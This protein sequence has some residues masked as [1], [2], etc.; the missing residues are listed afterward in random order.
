MYNRRF[1]FHHTPASGKRL[2]F[3]RIMI[4]IIAEK[5][6]V[7]QDIARVVGATE[8]KDGYI[9]GNG[10]MVTWALGHLVSLA[11]PDAYG[12]TRTAAEDLP[13]IPDPFRLVVRQ[14]RT[15]RGMV[16][17]IA[18]GRQLK[19]IGEV[20]AGC[21]SI[22]VA[23]DAGREG[24]L[25][26]RW[27]Y[28]YLGCTKPF[29]RLWISSLTDEA[30]REGMASLKEGTGYDSLYAA[31]DSRAK[32]DWLVGMNA[33]R[34]LAAA[35]G[36]V[37]NSIGR[38]QTPTLAMICA[39]FKENRNFVSTPYWQ[40]HIVLKRDNGHR[41]FIHTKEFKDKN[42]AEAAYKSITPGSVVTITKVKRG[43]I[44]QQAP[45]LYDLTALQKDCNI[46]YDLPVDKT[47]A[48]TQSLY[49][50]KLVSYPRTGSRYI[51]QDVM[52]HIPVLLEKI[53]A[54][55]EFREYRRSL[56]L[57]ALNT[58]SLDAAK[59]T[60]HHAIIPTIEITKTDLSA[61]PE[62]EMKILSLVANR[63]LCATG[64]KQLYETVKAEFSCGGY[65]F[66]VSGKTVLQNGWKEFE[67][68]LKR[69]Y[70]VEKTDED[71]E[72]KK[73]PELSEGMT[74]PVIQTKVTEHFTQPPKHFTE[75]SLL[76]AME[77]AGAED[78]GDEVERKGLGTPATRADIIEKL[79]KDGF[80][81]REKKQML[82]TEDGMKLITVL[83]DMVKSPKLTADWENTLTLVEKGEYTMQEFMDGIEDMVRELVQ[84]YHSISDDQK[85]LF[86][87]MQEVL[88]KCPKCGS[89][90]VKGKFGAYC[91]QKCG[92]N[93]GR[94]MGA[95]F[96]DTQMKSLLEGKKTL[97]RGLKGKKGSYDAYLIPEGIEDYSYIKDG[98]EIKGS[99]YKFKMEFPPRK[100]K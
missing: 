84:T 83:P 10:Y 7:G 25:I 90:V 57:S 35:S 47:L 66:H 94:A 56:D 27:I 40:L 39:R 86:G 30:I 32:A 75:D 63:L 1:P 18:A 11:L 16:T 26:F 37:N 49:E 97:V 9:V 24:E 8:K 65:S 73:L 14:V 52:A 38:V 80:V 85:S 33:S 91:K 23:T 98:K 54:M 17:D 59:V 19:V 81:K 71:K 68:A 70:R 29:K 55:P 74:F 92:M 79:V 22:I 43:K 99:Q 6:S 12:Y 89:D 15:D 95:T 87:T 96:S 88:G 48:I 51:P 53:T 69:T 34:A 21:E 58:R 78:M 46:H 67:A 93:V 100:S 44:F 82:P 61:V 36:S 72:E 31:A 77:R 4:A 3:I 20:L 62:G 13:M 41:Q 5:P 50:K 42:M 28:S 45:L 76:S 2:D 60:D 64:K